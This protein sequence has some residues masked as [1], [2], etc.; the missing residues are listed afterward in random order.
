MANHPV[1]IG[2]IGCGNISGIYCANA[3]T[4]EAIDLAACADLIPERAQE[5]AEEF[6]TSARS[7]ADLL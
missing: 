3:Q 2:L 5:K 6:D 7:V 4:L 1:K